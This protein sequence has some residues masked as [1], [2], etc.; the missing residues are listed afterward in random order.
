MLSKMLKYSFHAVNPINYLSPTTPLLR[1][2]ALKTL[3]P[4]RCLGKMSDSRFGARNATD[5]CAVTY[6]IRKNLEKTQKSVLKWRSSRE[7]S[8]S[9][10]LGRCGI[11]SLTD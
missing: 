2:S 6:H 1:L 8:K 4:Q 3:P 5:K 11:F 9:D 7:C 10:L